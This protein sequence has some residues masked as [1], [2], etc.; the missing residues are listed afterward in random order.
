MDEM[1]QILDCEIKKFTKLKNSVH[2]AWDIEFV[3]DPRQG[4]LKCRVGE[5][6]GTECGLN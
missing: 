6:D 4:W 3:L 5:A 1:D 2:A